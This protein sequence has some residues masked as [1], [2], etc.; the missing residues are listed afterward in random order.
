MKKGLVAMLF[1]SMVFVKSNAQKDNDYGAVL[2]IGSSKMAIATQGMFSFGLGGFYEVPFNNKSLSLYT[3]V[4]FQKRGSTVGLDGL[5]SDIYKIYFIDI[6][7]NLKYKTPINSDLNFIGSAGPLLSL[8]LSGKD[9]APAYTDIDGVRNPGSTTNLTSSDI[10]TL[11]FGF[12]IQTGVEYK[13]LSGCLKYNLMSPFTGPFSN[14]G[15]TRYLGLSVG[16][17]LN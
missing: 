6:N 12:N 17:K 15:M 13:K 5:G 11:T 2:S 3:E 1:L 7:P 9:E 10:K 8:F 16:Y 14:L 4:T